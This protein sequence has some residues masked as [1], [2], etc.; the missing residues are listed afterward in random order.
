MR[1]RLIGLATVCMATAV[2]QAPEA[3]ERMKGLQFLA[4]KWTGSGWIMMGPGQRRTFTQT[5]DVQAKLGGLILTVEGMGRNDKG[6]VSHHAF[7]VISWDPE[8]KAY[9]F[10]SH[11]QHG[12]SL[13]AASSVEDGVFEWGAEMGPR[14]IRYRIRLNAKGQWY[15]VGETAAA[16]G[17]WQKMFEMTLDRAR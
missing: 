17:P 6:E 9:R 10:R 1:L 2:A 4:G 8:G 12:R 16:G 3:I 13:D 5:E 7:A 11:D 15:E 14:R